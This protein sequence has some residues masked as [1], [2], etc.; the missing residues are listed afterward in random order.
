MSSCN[1]LSSASRS[2]EGGLLNSPSSVRPSVHTKHW[3]QSRPPHIN[4]EHSLGH[5]WGELYCIIKAGDS[6]ATRTLVMFRVTTK[7]R[8]QNSRILSRAS[9]VGSPSNHPGLQA[10]TRHRVRDP[11]VRSQVD[12]T[13]IG[14]SIAQNR[15]FKDF[16]DHCK[17]LRTFQ[18][19]SKILTE[20]QGLFKISRIDIKFK[21]IFKDVATLILCQAQG[22]SI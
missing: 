18:G 14:A 22:Y 13:Y 15:E 16:K 20:I 12:Q 5:K 10:E 19:S 8:R 2:E 21:D 7:F 11:L 1:V 9:K 4:N 17:S 6:R 3:S